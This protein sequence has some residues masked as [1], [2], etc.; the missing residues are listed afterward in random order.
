MAYSNSRYQKK[1]SDVTARYRDIDLSFT[2]NPVTKDIQTIKDVDSVRTSIK[3]IL[4]TNFYE[5]PFQAELG[6]GLRR[7][8]FEPITPVTLVSMKE[9]IKL[10][11]QNFEPRCDLRTV[12][13]S[14]NPDRNAIDIDI[15]FRLINGSNE[16]QLRTSLERTR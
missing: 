6:A 5:R 9:K 15:V 16:V 8:L 3:N 2:K 11:I 14:A 1:N 13:V 7:F 10:A 12:Q 4:H